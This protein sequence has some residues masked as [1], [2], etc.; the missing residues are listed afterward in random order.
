MI[1]LC[2]KLPLGMPTLCSY[3][4]QSPVFISIYRVFSR[5]KTVRHTSRTASVESLT[6]PLVLLSYWEAIQEQWDA[7]PQHV[8]DEWIVKYEDRR[9][10]MVTAKSWQ[11]KLQFRTELLHIYIYLHVESCSAS[12]PMGRMVDNFNQKYRRR[13]KRVSAA[14]RN[15]MTRT[16]TGVFLQIA[17]DKSATAYLTRL[18]AA[19]P[20]SGLVS[21]CKQ[22]CRACSGVLC[23][24]TLR[25]HSALD[26][27]NP[28]TD[29]LEL[30]GTEDIRRYANFL[31]PVSPDSRHS[32][33]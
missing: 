29:Q 10:Q 33:S 17:Q 32:R 24:S 11:T 5:L 13:Q 27:P 20:Q 25:A 12:C 22:R 23:A 19:A 16:C 7:T 1:L 9:L 14:V 15:S 28:R 4:L 18:P 2:A 31:T 26:T 6:S 8:I 3:H 21:E 30:G